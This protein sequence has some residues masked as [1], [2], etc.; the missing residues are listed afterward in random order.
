[1]FQITKVFAKR[2]GS[3]RPVYEVDLNTRANGLFVLRPVDQE[4]Y[5]WLT[6]A[7]GELRDSKRWQLRPTYKFVS[8]RRQVEEVSHV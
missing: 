5:R 6:V 2:K 1:M 3:D 7:A 4:P 8:D